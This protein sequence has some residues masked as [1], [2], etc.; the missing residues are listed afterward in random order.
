[1]N[2]ATATKATFE[3]KFTIVIRNGSNIAVNDV[4]HDEYDRV[5]IVKCDKNDF[6]FILTNVYAPIIE[7]LLATFYIDSQN[8]VV[9]KDFES[10]EKI[11]IGGNSNCILNAALD[12]KGGNVK[13]K[14][15]VVN[16]INSLM[17]VFDL[18]DVRRH[19]HPTER[20][21]TWRQNNPLL[22]CR[23]DYFLVSNN[24]L[25]YVTKT[26][27]NSGLRTDHSSISIKLQLQK[28]SKRGS[29][30]WKFNNSYLND[31]VYVNEMSANL[32]TWNQDPYIN[33]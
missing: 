3:I 31:D 18:I 19:F 15:Q 9:D 25:E 29:G 7:Q 27:I 10:T 1:M 30:Y 24:L 12:K 21:Y 6:N 33:D 17:D 28:C 16:N 32:R 5:L 23:L 8:I 20:R 2:S 4:Y 22:Q 26:D 14:H 11:I 13:L